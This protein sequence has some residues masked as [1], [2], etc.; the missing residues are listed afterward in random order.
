MIPGISTNAEARLTGILDPR[1][2]AVAEDTYTTRNYAIMDAGD[3]EAKRLGVTAIGE[4]IT[5]VVTDP[6]RK[7]GDIRIQSNGRDNTLFFDNLAWGGNCHASIRMLGSDTV[8]LFNDIGDEYVAMPDIYLRSNGQ[9]VFW[10]RGASAVGVSM[11][12][13]GEGI[14]VIVGD[15]ALISNGVWIRNHDM[16][17]IHDLRTGARI[18]RPPVQTVIERHVWLGQDAMLL[19]CERIGMGAIVGTGSLVKGTVPPRVVVA[20]TP[21]R[22]IREGVSWGR[23]N[24]GM[25]AAE[26]LSIGLPEEPEV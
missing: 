22:V 4:G 10:G 15:D 17:A 26:R 2:T 14:G 25:T 3:E 12:I 18:N 13:E 19:G 20:G 6:S 23:S 21:A 7:L 1:V 11:E 5:L 16:H 9:F 24:N 8:M